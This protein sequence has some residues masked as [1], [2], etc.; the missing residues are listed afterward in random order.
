MDTDAAS[1][2]NN[3]VLLTG[4]PEYKIMLATTISGVTTVGEN[5]VLPAALTHHAESPEKR[6]PRVSRPDKC[7]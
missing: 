6:F 3:N 2:N 5:S 1:G 7:W 4:Q